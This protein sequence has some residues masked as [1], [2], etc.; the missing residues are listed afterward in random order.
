MVYWVYVLENDEGHIY[1]GTTTR[2]F[3]RFNEHVSGNGSVNTSR[4]K[5]DSIIGLYKVQD[6]TRFYEYRTCILENKEYNRFIL[7]RW[8]ED[9]SID[10]LLIENRITERFLYE[11]QKDDKSSNM[12]F[13][14][15]RV[16][17]GKYT[18]QDYDIRR[19]I[20]KFNLKQILDRPLCNCGAPSEVKLSKEE[21]IY[22]ICPLK[23]IWKDF[24]TAGLN[25]NKPCDFFE[26]YNEDKLVKERWDFIK[27]KCYE[28]WLNNIPVSRYRINTD[29][30]IVCKRQNSYLGIFNGKV[31][32]LCQDC[33]YNNYNELKNQYTIS[34]KDNTIKATNACLISD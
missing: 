1:V 6:N 18:K 9:D 19:K 22:F 10:E 12:S 31:R 25:V 11:R 30:C 24:Y 16:K 23:N 13:E 14:N 17:G 34:F 32:T 7:E 28:Q 20:A 21:K 5:P 27:P 33:F 26:W 29:P 4:N 3:S 8:G 15:Y 2:L